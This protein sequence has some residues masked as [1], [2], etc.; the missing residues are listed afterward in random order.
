MF[1]IS[2]KEKKSVAIYFAILS[3]V[4]GVYTYAGIYGWKFYNP[5]EVS[6]RAFGPSRSGGSYGG[7]RFYHK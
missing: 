3:I 5:D 7:S 4:L 6:E 1:T 2:N